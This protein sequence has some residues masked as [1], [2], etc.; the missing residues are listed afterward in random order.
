MS[1]DTNVLLRSIKV[2]IISK[3]IAATSIRNLIQLT[4]EM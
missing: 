3:C 1:V 4:Q 2:I